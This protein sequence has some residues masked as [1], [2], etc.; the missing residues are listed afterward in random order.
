VAERKLRNRKKRFSKGKAIRVSDLVYA[1]LDIHRRARSWDWMLRRMLGLP[2]RA[3]NAQPLLEGYLE[4]TT[5]Q[6]FL[7]APG[8]DW[9]EAEM[10]ANE[11]AIRIAAK[12]R[13]KRVLRPI[14]M[15]ELP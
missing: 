5:G 15:R 10:N 8:E 6:F 11:L 9:E 14:R 4:V 7:R 1:T 2:D 3:G 12:Q 13:S